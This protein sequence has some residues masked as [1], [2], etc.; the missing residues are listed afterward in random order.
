MNK[1]ILDACCGGRMF[2]FDKKNPNVIFQDIRTLPKGSVKQR[3]NFCIFP[4]VIGDFRKMGYKDKSFKLVVF[5]PP[6]LKGAGKNG[7]MAK[8]YGNLNKNWQNDISSGFKE[9]WR[10]LDDYGIL[11]FKW[12]EQTIKLSEIKPLFPAD[13]LFGH[14]TNNKGNTHW[15]CFMKIPK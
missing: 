15:I 4:D 3:E 13:P 11:I 14:T 8:K 12:N 2:W 1:Y 6:H 7:W 5:D 9:C 10:V